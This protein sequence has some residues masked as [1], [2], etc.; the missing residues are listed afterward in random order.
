MLSAIKGR[1]TE[2]LKPITNILA[3]IGIK[4]NHLTILGLLLGFLCAYEIYLGN[5]TVSV[6]L[7]ILSSLM[8]A[9]DGALA[10]DKGM[11][12]EF[13]GF[14][15]SVLDRYVD[16][17]IF[18]ALG[19]QV[20][21]VLAVFALSGALMVSYTRAR[22]EKIIPKCDVGIAERGERLILIMIGLAFPSILESIVLIV[23][24]LSHLTALHRIIYTYK[25][26]KRKT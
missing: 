21:W 5:Y 2:L 19:F 17:A 4:P 23:G 26:C 15:D 8:D 3:K 24:I 22:A 18:F 1:T 14:L 25:E 12:T 11:I 10:R 9:L 20:G 6:I 13:G 16:I 7:L